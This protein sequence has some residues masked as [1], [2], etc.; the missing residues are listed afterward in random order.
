MTN[1]DKIFLGYWNLARE[2]NACTQLVSNFSQNNEFIAD[3]IK[4]LGV[5]GT[6]SDVFSLGKIF[7][8]IV[9]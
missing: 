2:I 8:A 3:Q 9:K 5:Y 1:D 6:E 4:K 7:K